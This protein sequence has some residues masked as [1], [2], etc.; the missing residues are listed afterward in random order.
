MFYERAGL[1]TCLGSPS[2]TGSVTIIGAVSPPAGDFSDPVTSATLATV[3][4]FWGLDKKLAH[5]KHF[6][7]IDIRSSYSSCQPP[8]S[9]AYTAAASRARDILNRESDILDIVHL[10]G[11]A[12]L[13]ETDKLLLD[14]A[15]LIRDHFL[16]Q[17]SY[18]PLDSFC[19]PAKTSAM[20]TNIIHY[21]DSAALH[22]SHGAL[23]HAIKNSTS[24]I[25]ASLEN[26]K[27]ISHSD[28]GAFCQ[29][30]QEIGRYFNKQ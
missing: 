18:H 15:R 29:I 8:S 11:T 16:L 25:I 6:P 28:D 5:R 20:L 17:N 26:M 14:I 21:Y 24:S 19:P 13:P 27:S 2:R 9:P 10:V 1:V 7:A 4:V 12:S 22:I 3:Q 30:H 23:W